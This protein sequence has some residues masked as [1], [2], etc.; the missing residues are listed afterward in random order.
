[1]P[2]GFKN[3]G[4]GLFVNKSGKVWS[5]RSHQFINPKARNKVMYCGD[6]VIVSRLIAMIY[7]KREGDRNIVHHFDCNPN[8]NHANNLIWVNQKEHHAMHRALKKLLIDTMH[9]QK[10]IKKFW[11]YY[12]EEIEK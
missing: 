9:T 8:N 6:T 3:I 2:K 12:Q 4:D 11:K 7:C 5:E 10:G 1:M